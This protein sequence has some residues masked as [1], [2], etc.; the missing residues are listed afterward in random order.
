MKFVFILLGLF[1]SIEISAQT[2]NI[3]FRN[4]TADDGLP[5]TSV[6]NI[7]SDVFGYIWIGAWDGVYRYDGKVF[8][9][10]LK[11]NLDGRILS[12][13]PEGN[14]WISVQH[15]GLIK[16]NTA[17]DSF[18]AYPSIDNRRFT[19]MVFTENNEAIAESD[20]GL[21]VLDD[22]MGQ[23]IVDSGQ[24]P[25]VVYEAVSNGSTIWF[26]HEYN[27]KWSI[28]TRKPDHSY[29][30]EDMPK[31][32]NKSTQSEEGLA[33]P[34]Y[35][36]PYEKEGLMLV[37]PSGWAT[38]K[39]NDDNWVFGR[40]KNGKEIGDNADVLLDNDKTLWI[41]QQRALVKI[42]IETGESVEYL[43]NPAIAN[44]ILTMAGNGSGSQLF[45][46]NQGIL[47]VSRFSQGISLLNT[48]A[49]DFGLLRDE[50]GQPIS[51][52]LS[53]Y[54]EEDGS[55][56]VGVRRAENSLIY[57]NSSGQTLK[58]YSGSYISP[59]GKTT[60][61]E[62]SHPF[63]WCIDQSTD[64]TIWIGTGSP[65]NT[66]GGMNK[67]IKDSDIITRFKHDPDD[68]TSISANW[69]LNVVVDGSDR[70]W[71]T[72]RNTRTS[73]LDPDTDEIIRYRLPMEGVIKYDDP[74]KCWA[75]MADDEGNIWVN[76]KIE[77]EYHLSLIDHITLKV[78][79]T[80]VKLDNPNFVDPHQDNLGRVWVTTENG[81]GYMIKPYNKTEKTIRLD[82]KDLPEFK[83][84]T[85]NSDDDNQ[86]WLG[87]DIGLIRLDPETE[88]CAHYG[89]VRGLQGFYF[90]GSYKGPS[91]KLY[92]WGNGG[93]NIF[94]PHQ[95]KSN[96]F[97]PDIALRDIFIDGTSVLNNDND[98]Y[99]KSENKLKIN[100]G[101]NVVNFE[102][103]VIHFGGSGQNEYKFLLEGFDKDWRNGNTDGR[104]TY[105]TLPKG[106]YTLKVKGKNFDGIWSDEV[107]LLRT[108]VF[109]P[110]WQTY[111]AYLGYF[112]IAG[113][114]LY[115][116]LIYQKARITR[117]EREK[118]MEK[119]LE[120][121]KEIEKAYAEL[122]AAQSQLIHAEKMASL[123]ELTAGIAHEIQNPL[124][125]V[126]NFSDL[127][128]ELIDEATEE[129]KNEELFETL[130]ILN[131]VKEN[132]GKVSHH[133]KRADRIV[134]NMLMHSRIQSGEKVNT[135]INQIISEYLNLAYHGMR[136]KHPT[137]KVELK[138]FLD[139][140][141]PDIKAR[142]QEI[143]RVL[144]NL[145][146]NAFQAV[147]EKK[148]SSSNGYEP[149]VVLGTKSISDIKDGQ[150][151]EISISD[152][153]PGIPME[154]EE[155][156]FQPFFT[157][158]PTGEGTG[159]GLSL[160][161]E[162]VKAHGGDILVDSDSMS[163]SIFRIKL[164]V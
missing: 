57:C 48:H 99:L 28:G 114:L 156:I 7:A 11:E 125:F 78:L 90:D 65:G 70:I 45:L 160:A 134:K 27:G 122:K 133:G 72:D 162:I 76:T 143:G 20:S 13:D 121:A 68:T 2:E 130:S 110:W 152:N 141:I 10:M 6:S 33:L 98:V 8:K 3:I 47:W 32:Q 135:D 155:K 34:I 52:I 131:D 59:P 107:V 92:F 62:L 151:I 148:I 127:S 159:L 95:I 56:W 97:P 157:T 29:H 118:S 103:A 44:S 43:P 16:Y 17:I 41:N 161:Y 82:N 105:T 25:G 137:F 154:L 67:L 66:P 42:D 84:T 51:D 64:G 40:L 111:W 9:K 58:T 21:V 113:I 100:H 94:D 19:Q 35:L 153:G 109:P 164:P 138:S 91:G 63:P 163:G 49:S 149:T 12:A 38:R 158:K 1:I 89:Y 124:N 144:L 87:T 31:D 22:K 126:N 136:A 112:I 108:K 74:S 120:Q 23:F 147:H 30:Y 93:I 146:T 5:I 18:I 39:N 128:I 36:I 123:G 104:I 140:K 119:E 71:I 50:D 150:L 37:T 14:I 83:V 88:S 85:I 60:S 69:I 129:L 117:V 55:Y 15:R 75:Y 26:F 53:A 54:E 77:G 115:L 24:M 96:P 101:V 81:I 132:L 61:N 4:I 102:I 116:F 142:P 139:E 80:P 73:I 46:D 79:N 106:D 145:I 86:I